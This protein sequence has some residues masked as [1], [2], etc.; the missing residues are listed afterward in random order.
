[1]SWDRASA[2]LQYWAQRSW[3]CVPTAAGR[4]LAQCS[5]GSGP[6]AAARSL[7]TAPPPGVSASVLAKARRISPSVGL[8]AGAFGSVVGVGG[9]VIIVPTIVNACKTIPQR[10]V[11]G[12]SLVAVLS[13]ALAS[14][15]T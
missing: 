4:S 1:M 14:A 15:G 2:E 7:A 10:L 12:T 8:L 3:G 9:G 6:A 13:T 11:S 5:R